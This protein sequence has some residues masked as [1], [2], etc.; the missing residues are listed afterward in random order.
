MHLNEL[1]EAGGD[2]VPVVRDN[3]GVRDRQA[4]RM[5]EQGDDREPVG[6][7]AD[8]R[9][10]GKG[11]K[12]AQSRMQV[13]DG[14]RDQGGDEGVARRIVAARLVRAS[15]ACAERG[16]TRARVIGLIVIPADFERLE[17]TSRPAFP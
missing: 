1:A 2:P 8:R 15:S 7:T 9:R 16:A 3:R 11:G 17:I 12:E 10:L 4:E 13:L 14:A 6:Q 5:P